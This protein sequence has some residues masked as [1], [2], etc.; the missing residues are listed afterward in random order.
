MLEISAIIITQER[1]WKNSKQS[2]H[3]VLW[4]SKWKAM[5]REDL[6]LEK[7]LESLNS[8]PGSAPQNLAGGPKSRSWISLRFSY[9]VRKMKELDPPVI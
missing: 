1:L 5:G 7:E 6:A 3:V 8:S 2:I 4:Q 9:L